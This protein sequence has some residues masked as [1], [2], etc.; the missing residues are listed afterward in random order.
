MKSIENESKSCFL[1]KGYDLME[2]SQLIAGAITYDE[3]WNFTEYS[4][5]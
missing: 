2:R 1:R 5:P 3:M 4:P